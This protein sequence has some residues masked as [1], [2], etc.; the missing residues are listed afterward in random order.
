VFPTRPSVLINPE[1][2]RNVHS[3][4][5]KEIQTH[6]FLGKNNAAGEVAIQRSG[7]GGG[8]DSAVSG[9]NAVAICGPAVAFQR[10]RQ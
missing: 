1:S 9:G 5:Q 7:V 10:R 6:L 2:S 3:R 8:G 4:T